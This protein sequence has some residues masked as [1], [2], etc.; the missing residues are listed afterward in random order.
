MA[1]SDYPKGNNIHHRR[2]LL[3]KACLE[4]QKSIRGGLFPPKVD[5]AAAQI[6]FISEK[7]FLVEGARK[8]DTLLGRALLSFPYL[9]CF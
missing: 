7:S 3:A 9:M 4:R 2:C 5:A 1:V 8:N 6:Q